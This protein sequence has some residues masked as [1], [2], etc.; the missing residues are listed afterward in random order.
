MARKYHTLLA[1]DFTLKLWCIEFGDYDKEVV[2]QE[3]QDFRDSYGH[4][5][6]EVNILTTPFDDQSTIEQYVANFNNDPF[7]G[8]GE[9]IAK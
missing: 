6:G 5:S 4:K 7:H 1:Y 8:I 2:K 3:M 9:R